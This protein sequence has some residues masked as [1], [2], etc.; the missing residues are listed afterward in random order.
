MSAD[1][2]SVTTVLSFAATF[3][4]G[5]L[6]GVVATVATF[7]SALAVLE[8]ASADQATQLGATAARI[9][10]QRRDMHGIAIK[11]REQLDAAVRELRAELPRL[12]SHA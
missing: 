7:R 3:C 6:F 10:D 9:E 4:A 5:G 1:G 2:T 11:F 8:R 12:T